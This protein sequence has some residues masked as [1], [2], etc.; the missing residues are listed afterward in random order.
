MKQNKPIFEN[1]LATISMKSNRG[2]IVV[3]PAAD[4][5]SVWA[6][7]EAGA[8]GGMYWQE[9]LGF[10]TLNDAMSAVAYIINNN[11]ENSFYNE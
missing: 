7:L 5:F 8:G 11:C 2:L 4:G 6:Q 1:I 3:T 10:T 9:T